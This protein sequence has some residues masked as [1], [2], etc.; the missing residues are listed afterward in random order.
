M[1]HSRPGFRQAVGA[2]AY[3]DY[4]R[5]AASLL[6]TSLGVQ[7]VQTAILWQVYE[8]TG[9]ALLLGLTGLARA[10]P[11]MVLSLVGG[12]VADRFNRVRLIQ[13]GQLTNGI[14]IAALA[15]LT[16]LGSVEVWHLY[17][18]TFLNSAFSA[19]TNPA[20]TALIPSLVPRDRL[21]NAVALNATIGQASQIVGPALA[22]VTIAFMGL[23]PTYVINGAVY[24]AAMIV[25]FG[26]Q[27]PMARPS[28]LETPWES[29]M[30]GLNFVRQK[31][32]IISLLLLDL[33]ETI[34]GS[35]RAL[36]PIIA[37][38]LG[39]GAT[40][41]GLLSAA[42]GVGAL[43]GAAFILGLG[44]MRYK[45]LYTVFGVLAYC[46]ALA[47]LAVSPWFWLAIIASVLL[48]ATNSIQMI[49]RNTVI[50]AISPDALR[51]RVEA[52]RSMLA[53]GGPPLGYTLSGGLA[54][55]FGAPIALLAG[56]AA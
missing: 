24:V 10:A 27:T 8:L 11:H 13:A 28:V 34:F 14:L 56:A 29:F 41:Y 33:G 6:L 48:G 4:R 16:I 3:R 43:A 9:S 36:L 20:R 38:N 52:F 1:A 45:G 7:L 26:I 15:A 39:V 25:I 55:V 35:Y 53:G 32:V 46:V 12:V 18:V 40:G 51:G 17:V 31:P 42:P 23:G 49:P 22:G 21:V 54:A 44:D 37:D 19:I 5:F 2:L 30:E 50:L 47:M